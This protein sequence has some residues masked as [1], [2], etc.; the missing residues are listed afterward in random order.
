MIEPHV[1]WMMRAESDLRGA[2]ILISHENPTTDVAIFHTQQCAE[3]ALKGFLA[4]KRAEIRKTHHLGELVDQCTVIDSTFDSLLPGA[5]TLTPKATEFRYF[6]NLEEI[7]D[8]SQLFPTVEEVE[9]AIAQAKRILE[10]VKT[11]IAD[12]GSNVSRETNAEP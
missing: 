5:H 2:E 4:F 12:G 11:K 6:G 9:S 8:I 3:K 10:F 7:D 1:A